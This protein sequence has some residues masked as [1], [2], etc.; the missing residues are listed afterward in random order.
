MTSWNFAASTN[1]NQ[2]SFWIN[3]T[4]ISLPM[5]LNSKLTPEATAREYVIVTQSPVIAQD[6][7]IHQMYVLLLYPPQS[8]ARHSDYGR[9]V[10]TYPKDN[11]RL[12][13]PIPRTSQKWQDTYDH[14][15]SAERV[16]KRQ[17]ND[18][19]LT[20]FRTRSKERL[21]FYSLLT[22]IAVHVD[23][24]FH[25]DRLEKKQAP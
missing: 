3:S 6:S 22:A 1:P 10:Y 4:S 5:V 8:A 12:Y 16:F 24:W 13:P 23:A 20:A 17:K 2:G 11:P 25:Q 21:F 9:V 18:L 19:K 15:T 14:R 7:S